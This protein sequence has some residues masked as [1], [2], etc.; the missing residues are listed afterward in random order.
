MWFLELFYVFV[1]VFLRS[2]FSGL[3]DYRWTNV[4]IHEDNKSRKFFSFANVLI[5]YERTIN[6]HE[7]QYK[8][9]IK[10]RLNQINIFQ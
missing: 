6:Y 8:D 5:Y 9:M 3:N 2:Y 7:N 4:S 10:S 1:N